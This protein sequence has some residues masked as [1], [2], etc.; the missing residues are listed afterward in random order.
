M[1]RVSVIDACDSGAARLVEP[2][3]PLT[4][5]YLLTVKTRPS[6][7]G[8]RCHQ[9][10]SA[11]RSSWNAQSKW[12]NEFIL[13]DVTMLTKHLL[14]LYS[15]VSGLQ[16]GLHGPPSAEENV[17]TLFSVLL[18]LCVYFDLSGSSL[19]VWSVEGWNCLEDSIYF[20]WQMMCIKVMYK[21]EV[22]GCSLRTL[23][24]NT[25]PRLKQLL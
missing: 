9:R 7:P 12:T 14:S 17:Q 25:K 22:P 24:L 6:V 23:K 15:L 2:C 16:A 4:W 1:Q 10:T 8:A 18:P 13:T 3:E 5:V 19:S 11:A 21:P 20:Q